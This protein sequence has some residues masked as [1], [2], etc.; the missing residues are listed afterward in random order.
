MLPLLIRVKLWRREY[1]WRPGMAA[2]QFMRAR[3]RTDIPTPALIELLLEESARRHRHL[4]PRQVLGVRL[5]LRGLLWLGLID[6]DYQPRYDNSNKRLLTIVETDG[7]GADGIAVATD[8]SV[9]HR[10][11]RLM[12]YGKVAATLVDT[13]GGQAVRVSP[14]PIARRLAPSFAPGAPSRWHAYLKAYAIIPDHQLIQAQAVSLTRTV[15]EILSK[16]DARTTCDRCGEEILNEREVRDGDRTL[17]L[18]CA[19]DSYYEICQ[20]Q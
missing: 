6:A 9:G 10:T 2:E 8:C 7:C 16:P 4:C 5:G 20:D 14:S 12:D 18:S 3:S 11:L 17:C 19:G 13:I 15:A 1:H